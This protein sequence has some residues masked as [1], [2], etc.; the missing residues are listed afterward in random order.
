[1]TP[2]APIKPTDPQPRLLHTK[3]WQI[4]MIG[5]GTATTQLDTSVNIA[6]PAI[7]TGFQ[8]AIGD[9]QW[10]VI[11]YVLT[12]ASLLLALGR[13]GDTIGHAVVFR[14]GLAWSAIAFLLVA[15]APT[16]LTML[17]ARCLQ[18]V[19]AALILSCSIALVT[20]LY[21]EE[22]R[23][24]ALGVYTMMM[25]VGVLLGP[26]IGGVLVALWDW[27]SVFWF[28]APIALATLV[29]LRGLPPRA[30]QAERAPF[31][32]VSGIALVLGLV[33][34]LL[35]INRVREWIAFPLAIASAAILSFF[36][37]RQRRHALPIIDFRVF[38]RPGFT[39]INLVSVLINA[40]AFSVWMLAPYFLIRVT[41]YSLAY[42]GA[43]LGAGAAGVVMASPVGGRLLARRLLSAESLAIAGAAG[44]AIGLFLLSRWTEQTPTFLR[45]AGL[46]TQG[47]GLGLFQ[48]AYADVVTAALPVGE[49]GVAGSV[50]LLTR[51]L[52]TVSAA[53]LLLMAFEAFQA[54][55]DFFSAF[56]NSFLIASCLAFAAAL[57]LGLWPRR[58]VAR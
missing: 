3:S 12:Y 31:D 53:S 30:A 37:L 17:I 11:S 13:I 9:I 26:L 19:G 10:V 46:L 2:P 38:H 33:T 45:V 28:R 34:L 47:I 54:K 42:S 16:Y 51:T 23:S 8:L 41:G 5:L 57:L 14:T 39:L 20:G 25:G 36:V 58:I 6:F 22:R 50:A 29:L 32:M 1:M 56:Q 52:G 40:A 7:T 27:P 44:V 55:G 4:A 43:I 49:R 15:W 48:L 18:G 35:T 24:W 21:G